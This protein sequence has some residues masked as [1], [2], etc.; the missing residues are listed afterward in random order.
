MKKKLTPWMILSLSVWALLAVMGVAGTPAAAANF[1]VNSLSDNFIASDKKCTL[2]EAILN[3]N[4]DADLTFGDCVAGSGV[5][6]ITFSVTGNI[7]LSSILPQITDADRLTIDGQGKIT[8]NGNQKVGILD[9]SDAVLVLNN[10]N[11]VGGFG[12]NGY[13]G[14]GGGGALHNFGGSVTVN[15]SSI[16]GNR[17]FSTYGASGGAILSFYGTLTINNSSFAG[18]SANS[19]GGGIAIFSSSATVNNCTFSGNSVTGSGSGRGGGIYYAGGNNGI[20]NT[21]T[22][23]NSAFSGN[24]SDSVGGG[25]YSSEIVK[26]YNSTFS[27]NSAADQGGGIMNPYGSLTVINSTISGNSANQGG[28]IM[29]DLYSDGSYG[30]TTTLLRNSIVADN[31]N[32]NCY[33]DSGTLTDGG[34]NLDDDGT[35]VSA[36]TSLTA[37]PLLDP[38]GLKSNGGPTKTIALCQGVNSPAGCTGLSP[39]I[40]AANNTVCASAPISNRDQRGLIRPWDGDFDGVH[41]CDIGAYEAFKLIYIPYIPL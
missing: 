16:S 23:S 5:D 15:N 22:V 6:N 33:N 2:R 21:L 19:V 13:G 31:S 25:L 40:D 38:A 27:G 3:A 7:V 35:C 4:A 18:N 41:V 29:N 9:V 11:M 10:L 1:V 28:G 8:L 12:F 24:S 34:Y 26:V 14:D 17:T 30:G 37:D 32:G 20:G 39:A 36:A